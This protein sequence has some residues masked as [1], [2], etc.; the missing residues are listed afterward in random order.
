MRARGT[1]ALL[2]TAAA[3]CSSSGIA[4]A[5]GGKSGRGSASSAASAE[6]SVSPANHAAA[7]VHFKKAKE[8]YQS[9]AYHEAAAE[10]EAALVLDPNAKELVFNLG[11]V[12]E[13]LGRIDDSLTQFHKYQT[14]DLTPAERTRSD[15]Y[16]RRLEGAKKAQAAAAPPPPVP[17]PVVVPP[18]VTPAPVDTTPPP[19]PSH[20]RIDAATGTTFILGAVGL[21]GGAAFGVVALATRPH[22]YMTGTDGQTYQ[23]YQDASDSYHRDATISTVALAVGGAALAVSAILFFARTND[24]SPPPAAA[25]VLAPLVSGVRF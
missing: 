13:R 22:N 6:P 18:P 25:L 1:Y 17:V 19:S 11:V 5:Q 10:L 23:S 12:D 7:Q 20:G 3:V 8:L 2:V 21:V 15:N 9:G 24:D 16:V 4:H 14:L